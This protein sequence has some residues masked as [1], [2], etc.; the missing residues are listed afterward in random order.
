MLRLPPFTYLMPEQIDEAIDMFTTHQETAMFVAG[1]TDLYPGMKRRIFEPKTLIS[2]GNLTALHTFSVTE[3]GMTLGSSMTL[4]QIANHPLIQTHYPALA[5]AAG[6]VST[7]QLRNVGT[8]GGNLCVDTRCTYYNQSESWREALGY[9]M[10]KDGHICWVATS[11]KKCLAVQS[12]DT[13]PIL[14]AL[15]A[16]VC[17]AGPNGTRWLPVAALYQNDGIHYFCKQPD[18]ILTKVYI[19]TSEQSAAQATRTTYHKLRR[20]GSFDFPVLSVA[21]ALQ[22]ADD[23]TCLDVRIVLGAVSSAPVRAKAAEEY[24]IGQQMTAE[25]IEE[26]A[27]KAYQPAKPLDNTDMTISYRKQMARV[28]VARALEEVAQI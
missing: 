12:S 18:E 10:K 24:L 11:S 3:D 13:A 23:G 19:P 14:I 20:R 26:A 8:L 22:Q 15:D 4:T 25:T 16:Q 5:T 7:P 28:Y 9:C 21:V 2:L 27:S 17:L 6:L 1:G